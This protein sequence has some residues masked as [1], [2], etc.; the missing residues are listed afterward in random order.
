M[1][2]SEGEKKAIPLM[3]KE[4][5]REI[6]LCCV[7][8]LRFEGGFQTQNSVPNMTYAYRLKVCLIRNY[9]REAE[10]FKRC[11]VIVISNY[12]FTMGREADFESDDH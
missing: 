6:K 1:S 11:L 3:K 2:W 10:F 8:P 12:P 4:G 5:G 9:L 7:R